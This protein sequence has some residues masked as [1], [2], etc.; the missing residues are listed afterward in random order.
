[1]ANERSIK[2]S[3]QIVFMTASSAEE[4]EKIAET[5]VTE[6][7]AACINIVPACRSVYRWQGKLVKDDEVLIIAKTRRADFTALEERVAELHSYDVPEVIA[8]DLTSIAKGYG[9]FL[10]ELLGK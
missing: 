6:G 4:G 1:V 7:L 9:A 3:Y 10:S 2:V 5:L 8:V